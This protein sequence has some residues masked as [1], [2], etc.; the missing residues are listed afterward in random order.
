LNGADEGGE[1]ISGEG[2]QRRAGEGVD[3]RGGVRPCAARPN[4]L[5]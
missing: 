4:R 3:A 2:E 1:I 5:L